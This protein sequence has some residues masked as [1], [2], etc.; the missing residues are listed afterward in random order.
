[1]SATLTGKI[2]EGRGKSAARA[3]RRDNLLPGV[4]Y[5]MGDNVSFTV[6][7]KELKKI[8]HEGG[9]NVLIDLKIEGDSKGR[10]V[11]LKDYQTH[12]LKANWR[13]V[14][15]LEVDESK[16]IHV[17][18]PVVLIGNSPGEKQGGRVNHILKDIE[19]ECLPG[20]IIS[21]IEVNMPDIALGQV[22]HVSE[23]TLPETLTVLT[24]AQSAV[25]GVIEERAKA[26]KTTEESEEET[27]EEKKEDAGEASK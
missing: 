10:K 12:P 25:V 3:A 9:K 14:D 15:F 13:H 20:D 23:L 6:I 16:K 22:L 11:V 7:E 1:M 21:S 26:E 5:G 18:I 24:P 19:V 27:A 4:L 2:R 17:S 8:V